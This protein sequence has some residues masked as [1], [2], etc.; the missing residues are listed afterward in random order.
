MAIFGQMF[1]NRGIYGAT[2]ILSSASVAEMTRNQIPGVSAR[3]GNLLFPEA[4]WGLGW[5]TR[6]SKQSIAYAETLQSQQAFSHG[7]AG[8][9][10][11]WVD[12]AYEIVGVYFSVASLGGV[13][14]DVTVPQWFG[15]MELLG[16]PDLF[17]NA[18]TA[19]AEE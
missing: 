1:L 8:G 9:V 7:G 5:S 3:Y 16:R 15:D 18:V 17:I 14:V 10:F 12:P 19:A 6:E 2:R 4:S 11:M 13:P